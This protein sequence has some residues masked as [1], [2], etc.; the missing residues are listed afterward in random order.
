MELGVLVDLQASD[1]E[2]MSI[3]KDVQRSKVKARYVRR[4]RF[5]RYDMEATQLRLLQ[6]SKVQDDEWWVLS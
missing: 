6:T 5:Q 4:V 1:G 2:T 3:T